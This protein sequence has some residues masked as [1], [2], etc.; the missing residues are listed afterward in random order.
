MKST[1]NRSKL[2]I[3]T[4]LTGVEVNQE[5]QAVEVSR[6]VSQMGRSF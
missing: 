6:V 2:H 5:N 3:I 1:A 4:F